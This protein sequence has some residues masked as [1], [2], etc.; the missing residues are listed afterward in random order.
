MIGLL[1]PEYVTRARE[2]R[3][4]CEA[5]V[6][7]LDRATCDQLYQQA[8]REGQ[9]PQAYVPTAYDIQEQKRKAEKDAADDIVEAGVCRS[10]RSEMVEKFQG[11]MAARDYWPAVLS[12]RRCA[13]LTKDPGLS[14]MVADAEL[15][16]YVKDIENPRVLTADRV[17]SIEALSRDYPEQGKKYAS[18]LKKLA[19]NGNR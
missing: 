19:E 10:K 18:L 3:K 14:A 8:L 17:R 4:A 2:I 15:K 6:S 11:L 1:T 16:S 5:L 7:P 13:Q 12:L 9:P